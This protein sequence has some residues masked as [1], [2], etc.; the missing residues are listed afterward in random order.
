[1]KRNVFSSR[2]KMMTG[3]RAWTADGRLFRAQGAATA[4]AQIDKWRDDQRCRGRQLEMTAADVSHAM[5]ARRL[6]I[7]CWMEHS[8]RKLSPTLATP[9]TLALTTPVAPCEL[10][11]R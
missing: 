2:W 5:D 6:Y 3:G 10:S 7:L 4:K 9:T 8:R 11:R 1:M